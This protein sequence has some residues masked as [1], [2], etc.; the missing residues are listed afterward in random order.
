MQKSKK[1][2]ILTDEDDAP[3]AGAE[4]GLGVLERPDVGVEHLLEGPGIGRLGRQAVVHTDDR[5]IELARPGAHV[6]LVG[7]RALGD[8]A[9][10]VTVDQQAVALLGQGALDAARADLPGFSDNFSVI[11]KMTN[12]CVRTFCIFFLISKK[13]TNL[14][15]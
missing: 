12:F 2:N 9:A 5:Q 6:A 13:Q 8:E 15:L 4:H 11:G 7:A 1:H 14:R 3:G 10:P